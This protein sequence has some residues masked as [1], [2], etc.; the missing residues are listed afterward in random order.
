MIDFPGNYKFTSVEV[1]LNYDLH[2]RVRSTYNILDFIGDLGGI[3]DALMM[4]GIF[5]TG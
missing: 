3:N 5:F 2:F 1:W 4:I